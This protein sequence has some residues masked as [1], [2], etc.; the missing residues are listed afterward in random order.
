LADPA[1]KCADYFDIALPG[2]LPVL[3]KE[4]LKL[5]VRASKALK[6]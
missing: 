3:N 4:C 1:N 6:G 5:A 2:T